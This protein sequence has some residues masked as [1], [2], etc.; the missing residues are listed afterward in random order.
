MCT[1]FFPER[2]L[3]TVRA[4]EPLLHFA[5]GQFVLLLPEIPGSETGRLLQFHLL[6][7]V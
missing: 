1:I 3:S 2:S 6:F 7:I 5:H 4:A